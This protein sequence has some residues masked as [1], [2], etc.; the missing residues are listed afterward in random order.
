MTDELGRR[1][2]ERDLKR[3]EAIHPSCNER[4]W[5]GRCEQMEARMV[6]LEQAAAHFY[7]CSECGQD[8]DPCARGLEYTRALGLIGET[9]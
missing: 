9:G 1:Q 7:T 6:L 8:S 4:Y 5:I 3:H 2:A